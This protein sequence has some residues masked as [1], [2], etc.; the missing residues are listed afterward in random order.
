MK[1]HYK[2]LI[3]A[4]F[5]LGINFNFAQSG[6]ID[7]TREADGMRYS[8]SVVYK[9]DCYLGNPFIAASFQNAKILSFTYQGRTFTGNQLPGFQFP[10]TVKSGFIDGTFNFRYGINKTIQTRP[11]SNLYL[12]FELGGKL[13]NSFVNDQLKFIDEDRVISMLKSDG[14][15]CQ[16][17]GNNLGKIVSYTISDVS[18]DGHKY[19][20]RDA[21]EKLIRVEQ[22]A[23]EV[24]TLSQ[25]GEVAFKKG[26]YRGAVE[27]YKGA[28]VLQPDNEALQL[29]LDELKVYLNQKINSQS[30]EGEEGQIAQNQGSPSS[31]SAETKSE[32]NQQS[33]QQD[34]QANKLA[35]QRRQIERNNEKMKA[36]NTAADQ[37]LA[38]NYRAAS[39]TFA[40]AGMLSETMITSGLYIADE[41][42]SGLKADRQQKIKSTTES[43][44]GRLSHLAE[45]DEKVRQF[46][47]SGDYDRYFEEEEK[48]GLYEE[49]A[50]GEI[51][52]LIDKAKMTQLNKIYR[53][54]TNRRIER[55]KLIMNYHTGLLVGS[56]ETL[57][58]KSL[59]NEFNRLNNLDKERIEDSFDR[60]RD[61]RYKQQVMAEFGK[62]K[63]NR[64]NR[65][66]LHD[67]QE[68]TYSNMGNRLLN[69]ISLIEFYLSYPYRNDELDKLFSEKFLELDLNEQK[70]LLRDILDVGNSRVGLIISTR[71]VGKNPIKDD[72]KLRLLLGNGDKL[73]YYMDVSSWFSRK[74]SPF[75]LYEYLDTQSGYVYGIY[76]AL[77]DT[78]AN[79]LVKQWIKRDEKITGKS[80][81]ELFQERMRCKTVDCIEGNAIT[82]EEFQEIKKDAK[83]VKFVN[84][85]MRTTNGI[86]GVNMI[87]GSY[88]KDRSKYKKSRKHYKAALKWTN[89]YLKKYPDNQRLLSAKSTIEKELA[90]LEVLLSKK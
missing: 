35:N 44:K 65:I 28:I 67:L 62:E 63:L 88:N 61:I 50:L 23:S 33:L 46:F 11:I 29:R 8:G 26:D 45:L 36:Y 59:I 69:D 87:W 14:L 12:G 79:E 80:A 34:Y 76:S 31:N 75:A 49:S 81:K 85:V 6:R 78:K 83:E 32:N 13:S 18:L 15:T 16:N 3:L 53:E 27:Y 77:K 47:L 73:N 86:I 48:L 10:I 2:N 37:V 60:G 66:L 72:T 70:S 82:A 9:A 20:L 42:I 64:F 24:K 56:F 57:R 17:W 7:F 41:I 4:F 25:K 54:I 71:L 22:T 5:L 21:A 1:L 19:S 74:T 58:N 52:W 39:Y 90:E 55:V 89:T 40:N 30:Q 43:V 38:G 68:E 84:K 51:Y